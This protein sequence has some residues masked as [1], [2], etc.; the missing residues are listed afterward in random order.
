MKPITSLTTIIVSTLAIASSAYS[1]SL[2]DLLGGKTPKLPGGGKAPAAA[3]PIDDADRPKME[4]AEDALSRFQ[5]ALRADRPKK[6]DIDS[7][8]ALMAE[9]DRL[10]K[11][12]GN[13]KG[14]ARTANMDDRN[15][16]NQAAALRNRFKDF[17]TY[18]EGTYP[19]KGKEALELN[20]QALRT[21]L[22]ESV[23]TKNYLPFQVTIPARI[24]TI[25]HRMA[26]YEKVLG[27]TPKFDAAM[28][29]GAKKLFKEVA[30]AEEKL[31]AEIIAQNPWPKES[32]GGSDLESL[33]SGILAAINKS[34]P[35][36][37]VIEIVFDKTQWETTNAWVW[38]GTSTWNRVHRSSLEFLVIVAG[39]NPEHCYVRPG[40]VIKDHL[41]GDKI[42]NVIP[43]DYKKPSPSEIVLKSKKQ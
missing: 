25:E 39:E 6:E 33:R 41:L 24:K 37:K 14:G 8:P 23:A 22:D 13:A 36:V 18:V 31:A 28:V 10:V 20:I 9:V 26:M 19:K 21:T 15:F 3:I 7:Y 38:D 5:V 35:K 34:F 27:G 30:E 17:Q 12:Y 40:Y 1:Q 16:Y 2:P 4:A 29:E 32:Y 43:S 11:K 42:I